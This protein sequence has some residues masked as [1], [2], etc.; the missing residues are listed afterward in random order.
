MGRYPI[1]HIRKHTENW[2]NFFRVAWSA[3]VEMG[4]ESR[5]FGSRVHSLHSQAV[6]LLF[7][8]QRICP[9]SF[10][11]LEE[12]F[13]GFNLPTVYPRITSHDAYWWVS[14]SDS[15]LKD[16]KSFFPHYLKMLLKLHI[17]KSTKY[18]TPWIRSCHLISKQNFDSHYPRRLAHVPSRTYPLPARFR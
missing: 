7:L 5:Q 14:F 13:W 2:S 6:L 15:R 4:S 8:V 3:V 12:S 11:T 1:L 9:Q 16:G 10:W 17:E 18:T